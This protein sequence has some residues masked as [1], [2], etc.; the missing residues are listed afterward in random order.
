MKQRVIYVDGVEVID[1]PRVNSRPVGPDTGRGVRS[2]SSPWGRAVL[3]TVLRVLIG[4]TRLLIVTTL[5]I[6]RIIGMALDAALHSLDETAST[7][8]DTRRESSGE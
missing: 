7:G 6:G 3:A 1:T 2:P 4:A 8:P 5:A